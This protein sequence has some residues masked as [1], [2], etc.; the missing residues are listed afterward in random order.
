MTRELSLLRLEKEQIETS[1]GM[2]LQAAEETIAELEQ[3]AGRAD[4]VDARDVSVHAARGLQTDRGQAELRVAEDQLL[5]DHAR[6]Q[7]LARAV[8][9]A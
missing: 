1:L 9:V 2:D 7:D 5:R 3:S 8:H 4:D 6:T